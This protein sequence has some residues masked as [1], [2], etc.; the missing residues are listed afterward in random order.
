MPGAELGKGG[1]EVAGQRLQEGRYTIEA[2]RK[3]FE[4]RVYEANNA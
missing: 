1:S 3:G 2:Y 4:R